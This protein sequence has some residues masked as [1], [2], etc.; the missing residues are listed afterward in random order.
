VAYLAR[1]TQLQGES[2][3][4]YIA[5]FRKLR[6]RC[7]TSLTEKE[8]VSLALNFNMRE[9]FERQEFTDL[10]HLA[11][12]TT[13]VERLLKENKERRTSSKGTYYK[14]PSLEIA[15]VE[16]DSTSES[17]DEEVCVAELVQGKPY[18][19]SALTKPKKKSDRLQKNKNKSMAEVGKEYS[20]D[21]TKTDEIF[22]R[23]L[24]EQAT[25]RPERARKRLES[26]VSACSFLA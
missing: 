26:R 11:T 6:T 19:C 16:Y 2:V 24:K 25:A 1:V 22:D 12:R 9:K 17:E 15:V 21:I 14:D 23:L 3:E 18:E 13:S 4:K 8:C 5:R 7:Q 10:C 20:F